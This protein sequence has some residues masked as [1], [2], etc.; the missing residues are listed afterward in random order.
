MLFSRFEVSVLLVYERGVRTSDHDSRH[1]VCNL[2]ENVM[3]VCRRKS[4]PRVARVYLPG[5]GVL[6]NQFLL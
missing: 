4:A 1:N 6:D 3:E 5:R 2:C